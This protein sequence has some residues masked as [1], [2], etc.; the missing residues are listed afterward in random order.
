MSIKIAVAGAGSIGCYV[1]GA[2]ALA[3]HDVQFLARTRIIQAVARVGAL[4]L[5]DYNGLQASVPEPVFTDDLSIL[6][7]ADVIL[8]TV[9]SSATAE[10]ARLIATHAKPDAL[11]ISLQNGVGNVSVL[12]RILPDHDV[13]AGMVPFNVVPMGD[14]AYH[15]ATSGEIEVQAGPLPPLD[16]TYIGWRSVDNIEA[17]QWGKLLINLGNALNALSDLPLLDMLNQRPWRKLMADQM[18]EALGILKANGITPAKTTA[19]PPNALPFILRLP[20]PIFRRVAAKMLTIDPKARS[21]MWDD[22]TQGRQTEVDALQGVII[23][24]AAKTGKSAALNS[25]IRALIR[26]AETAGNGPPGLSP[27]DISD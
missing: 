24:L 10:I 2:L 18:A 5:S 25:R 3:G 16:T 23:D 15:R 26:D 22:L 17:V 11:I 1:G 7:V 8:V 20:T 21:S 9:K 12:R 6:G 13:R 4:K 27:A 19:V 14:A